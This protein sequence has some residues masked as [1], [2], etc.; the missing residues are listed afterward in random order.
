MD[1]IFDAVNFEKKKAD[2]F[3]KKEVLEKICGIFS[4]YFGKT[5]AIFC[6]NVSGFD[7][8]KKFA[9]VC[10]DGFC[11]YRENPINE[12]WAFFVKNSF[13]DEKTDFLEEDFEK[14]VVK[15]CALHNEKCG[16]KT[17]TF[18]E[19]KQLCFPVKTLQNV[20]VSSFLCGK[21]GFSCE[22]EIFLEQILR[23]VKSRFIE[24]EYQFENGGR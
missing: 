23:Q 12:E 5:S 18:A 3:S 7:F 20:F 10:G 21:K 24:W 17:N 14:S 15:W 8:E 19:S 1:S 9:G 11:G 6:Y 22:Q 13:G 4:S 16:F 2:D